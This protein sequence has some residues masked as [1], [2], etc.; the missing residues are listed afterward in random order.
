MVN[1]PV[2]YC[3][4]L[5]QVAFTHALILSI[6]L[7]LTAS[8]Q[9]TNPVRSLPP[10]VVDLPA[11]Q[12]ITTEDGRS[13]PEA[14]TKPFRVDVDLVLVPITVTDAKGRPITNLQKENF[15]VY[16]NGKPQVIQHFSKEDD[17]ISL[18]LILD[19]S[20]SMSNKVDTERTAISEFFKSAN[21]QDDY[22]VIGVSSRPKMIAE[23]TQS[24]AHIEAKLALETPQGTTALL[25]AVY[26]AL[27]KMP[28]AQYRRRALLIISDGGD[29][30]SRYRLKHIK[31]LAQEADVEIYAIGLFDTALFKPFEELMG[32]RWLGEITDATGG[33]TVTVD[34]LDKLPEV[35]A[36]IS[37]ELRNQYLVAYR[38]D[39]RSQHSDRRQIQIRV[40]PSHNPALQV[41]YRKSYLAWAE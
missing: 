25:D 14:R 31:D 7:L 20:Q 38:P 36:A 18:G 27:S 26:L 1:I 5:P 41:Y 22:F 3:S 33:R 11:T 12:P 16:E 6:L 32:K 9:S 23:S 35:A 24:P 30:N 40:V 2:R 39:N 29:N 21:S 13:S 28:S 34:H 17:P 37:W 15:L 19:F 8:G 10:E 4:A